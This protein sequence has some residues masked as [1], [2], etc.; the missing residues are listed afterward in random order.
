MKRVRPVLVTPLLAAALLV[1]AAP[2][3]AKDHVVGTYG[4]H[5]QVTSTSQSDYAADGSLVSRIASTTTYDVHG[6]ALALST[7]YDV[8]GL[9]GADYRTVASNVYDGRDR[10][11]T[12]TTRGYFGDGSPAGDYEIRYT[13]DGPADYV[14]LEIFADYDGDGVPEPQ[15]RLDV[16][17][18]RQGRPVLDV[19]TSAEGTTGRHEWTYDNQG[20]RTSFVSTWYDT[21]GTL[22]ERST[23]RYAYPSRTD[24]TITTEIDYDGDG[25]PEVTPVESRQVG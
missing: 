9:P 7:V 20:R 12:S 8:D 16:T 17:Y 4:S 13:Y 21:E 25:V 23:T 11:L 18:D 6:S 19:D 2:A 3:T 22:L 10:L 24:Y 1:P 5:D 14:S 15:G